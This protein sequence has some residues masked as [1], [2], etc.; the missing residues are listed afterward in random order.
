MRARLARMMAARIFPSASWLGPL[1]ERALPGMSRVLALSL[2]GAAVGLAAPMVTKALIDRGIMARDMQAL[3]TWAAVGFALGL[4]VVGLGIV[5][6][7]AH[8]RASQ[9]MLG[10]LRRTVLGAALA[11]DPQ[12]QALTV[13]EAQTRIDGDCAEI[14]RFLFDSGLVAVTALFRLVGGTALMLAL[15]WRLALL[16]ALAAPFE[17]WFLSWAR[18]RTQARAEE[19]REHRGGLSSQL[20]ETFMLI[21]GLRALNA[22]GTRETGFGALQDDLFRAQ[23]RQR[24]WTEAVGAVSQI[25]TAVVRSA[26]LLLGGWLVVTGSWPIGSLIAFLAYTGMMAGPLR[27]LL[28]LYHAQARAKVALAR[29]SGIVDDAH[30]PADGETCPLRPSLIRLQGARSPWGGHAPV[31]L[32]LRAGQGVLL[33]GPSGIGKSALLASLTGEVALAEGTAEIDG[34]PAAIYSAASRREAI[35]HVPQRPC[36]LR[37]TLRD[38]LLVAAPD[39]TDADCREVLGICDLLDWAD[40][41]GGLDTGLTELGATLSGGMRQRITI[42]RALLRPSGVLIFDESFSEID[43]ARCERILDAIDR[44]CAD[45]LRIFVAHSGAVRARSYD[46]R[47]TLEAEPRPGVPLPMTRRAAV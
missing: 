24:L 17:L 2:F 36:I 39:A 14:Q 30:D 15:D 3:V 45:R 28:G 47:I 44:A 11:R 33:D 29:L 35:T 32:E 25:L 46:Q 5:S 43:A 21:P 13:G 37:G 40:A 20:A 41:H 23:E 27:N 8:L 4:G 10:D 12:A 1:V 34:K 26:V 18:P 31:A 16:P 9:A 42:A 22:F 7:M 38:N 6:Q 19:V